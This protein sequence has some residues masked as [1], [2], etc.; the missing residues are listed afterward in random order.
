MLRQQ[1]H[2]HRGHH[3]LHHRLGLHHRPAGPPRHWLLLGGDGDVR[4]FTQ[5]VIHCLNSVAIQRQEPASRTVVKSAK[6][7]LMW[8]STRR[9][10]PATATPRQQGTLPASYSPRGT[11]QTPAPPESAILTMRLEQN[12]RTRQFNKPYRNHCCVNIT[13][14]K[15]FFIMCS[16]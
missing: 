9:T 2:L 3:L 7:P 16:A 1:L 14:L 5:P 6:A 4:S 10:G 13:L 12:C 8:T 15:I 11:L